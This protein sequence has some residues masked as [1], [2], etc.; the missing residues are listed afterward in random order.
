MRRPVVLALLAALA[1]APLSAQLPDTPAAHQLA[2][3][4]H[5]F[6]SGDRDT[7]RQFLSANAEPST[8]R[9]LQPGT[10]T[11]AIRERT[12]GFDLR[13]VEAS[14][15]D[16]L[17]AL[18]QQK[19]S[20]QIVRL[21]IDVEP[22]APNRIKSLSAS[23]L[24]TPPELAPARMSEA[25]LVSALRAKLDRDAADGKFSGTVLVAKDGRTVFAGAYGLAD[26]EHGVANT[27]DTEFRIA[28]MNKMFTAVAVLQLVQAGRIRL[29]A[30][31]GTYLT[32]YPN[33]DVA[34]KVTIH[35]LLTHTGGTGD[36][37]G[38]EYSAHRQ[39]LRNVSDYLKLFGTRGL[40]F[41]PGSRFDYSNYG[42]ILLGAV[43]EKV[44][45]MNYYDYVAQHVFA[46]AGM[47]STAS[48]PEDMVVARLAVGYMHDSVT[49]ALVPNTQTL[50]Y[51]GTS[52]GGGYSTVGDLVRFGKALL[53]HKLL[54]A[55]HTSLLT[56][57]KIDLGSV[58]YAYGFEEESVNGLRIIGHSGGAPGMNGDIA[59]DPQS[60]YVIAALSNFDPLAA[61]HVTQYV[62]ARLPAATEKR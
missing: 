48:F 40:E 30:P 19:E 33:K 55:E 29:D 15:A 51:R 20:D 13:R 39:E 31:L 28:S 11:I 58:K 41:E 53:E 35:Q 9:L 10:E 16:H 42:Y 7:L 3:W 14:S 27:M 12:G 5:A 50:P 54:D 21:T 56:T 4:L 26:R 45:G 6:N 47:T 8:Q 57:G 60:G 34:G 43:I 44:S 59:I 23:P 62:A 36:I 17:S 32:D 22:V 1:A 37:F 61:Q 25:E 46:P 52:A 2:G 38:P 49:R 18:A 24:P